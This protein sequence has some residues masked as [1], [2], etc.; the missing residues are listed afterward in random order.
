MA[1]TLYEIAVETTYK[2]KG[3]KDAAKDMGSV[4]LKA[5]IAAQKTAD[6]EKEWKDLARQVASGS[7]SF[8]D[9]EKEA[10]KLTRQMAELDRKTGKAGDGVEKTSRNWEQMGMQAAAAGGVLVGVGVAAKKAYEFIGEGAE[11]SA[12]AGKFDNLAVS[13]NTTGDA[14]LDK[15]KTAT[16]GMMSDADLI[17]SA[18][19]IMSL[20]LAKTEDGVVRMATAVGALDLDMQVLAL[21]L[22]NDSTMRLD[23]L[24]LSLEAVTARKKELIASGFIGDAFDEAVLIELEQKM[25]LLGDASD[26]TA[27]QM[28]I[29]EAAA[30]TLWQNFKTGVA[31]SDI[32][33]TSIKNLTTVITGFNAV[34]AA[35][36][37]ARE[38]LTEAVRKGIVTEEEAYI[39]LRQSIRGQD[40]YVEKLADVRREVDALNESTADISTSQ[41]EYAIIAAELEARHLAYAESLA[42]VGVEQLRGIETSGNYADALYDTADAENATSTAAANAAVVIAGR[43]ADFETMTG[44]ASSMAD[45]VSSAWSDEAIA[46]EDSAERQIAANLAIQESYEEAA[47]AV[48]EGG[49]QTAIEEG[50]ADAETAALGYIAMQEALGTITSE[51]AEQLQQVAIETLAIKDATADMTAAFLEDGKLTRDEAHQMAEKI[52]EISGA[53]AEIPTEYTVKFYADTT[54]W[55]PPDAG[56]QGASGGYQGPDGESS[57]GDYASGGQFVVPSGYPNDSYPIRV[58]SGERVTVETPQQ[59]KSGGMGGN[60]TIN[61]SGGDVA[62]IRRVLREEGISADSRRRMN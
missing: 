16:K 17:A 12:A 7:K 19:D 13:I 34:Q 50:G 25:V 4:S 23:N 51:E 11:L 14:L 18:S 39:I 3:A 15:L 44:A 57:K 55:N 24:G 20:G 45:V 5:E 59:M 38:D 35:K 9:A 2:G 58:Q 30:A 33:R 41:E 29:M 40:E 8:S 52:K 53:I 49:L 10:D 26:T 32:V 36:M 47:L 46:A 21:T 6:L 31:D 22:A 37:A 42:T 61:I 1:R 27:G 43:V 54:R 48:V 62:Q 28:K 60:V 56:W